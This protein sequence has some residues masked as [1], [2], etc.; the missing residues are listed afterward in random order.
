MY[1]TVL[2]NVIHAVILGIV[3]GITEFLPV[4]STFHLIF[5]SQVMGLAQT[6]FVKLFEVFIQSGA[7][8]SA[9]LLYFHDV[10][11][12]KDLI[13]HVIFSFIPTAVIG[14]ILYKVIK[15][16]FFNSPLL[17]ISVFIGMGVLFLIVEYFI[18]KGKIKLEKNVKAVTVKDALLIGVLQSIAVIPGVSRAG[19]VMVGMMKMGYRR[20]EAARYSFLL[21]VPT[22]MAASV[23]DLYK[24]TDI[25]F[26]QASVLYLLVVGLVVSFVVSYIVMKWFIT[27]LQY[28]SL[29]LFG[30]YRIILGIILALALVA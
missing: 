21:A 29:K 15:E 18:S 17:M 16:L 9:I 10:V 8:F 5:T 27:Y 25:L 13:K 20:D 28:N 4:S 1:Y 14:L 12:D 6:D 7:I 24:M 19:I 11:K 3:E 23:L 30:W 2:M 26:S 22:I